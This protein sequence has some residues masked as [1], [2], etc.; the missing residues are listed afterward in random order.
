MIKGINRHMIEVTDIDNSYYEKA[1]LIVRP[2]YSDY[3]E[4]VLHREARKLVKNLGAPSAACKKHKMFY[5]LI[6][7]AGAALVGAGITAAIFI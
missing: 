5:W 7:M 2:E 3:Q 4:R 1:F 6:R